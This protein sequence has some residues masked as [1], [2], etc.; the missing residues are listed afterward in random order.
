MVGLTLV[1]LVAMLALVVDLGHDYLVKTGL[2]NGADAAALA[3]AKS[4]NGKAA[5]V[6]NAM[7][8]AVNVA[9][10]WTCSSAVARTT[11]A[12]RRSTPSPPM[13]RPPG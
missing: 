1:V 3:G 10:D 8:Q 4:L 5:G 12:C 11:A 13:P 9:A 6:T 7:Q 2:Q